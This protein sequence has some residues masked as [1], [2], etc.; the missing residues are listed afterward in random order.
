MVALLAFGFLAMCAQRPALAESELAEFGIRLQQKRRPGWQ[1]LMDAIFRTP[2]QA[3]SCHWYHDDNRGPIESQMMFDR[4]ICLLSMHKPTDLGLSCGVR[5]DNL[6][7]LGKL[8]HLK[9]LRLTVAS[10]ASL[11]GVEP[12][13]KL[14]RLIVLGPAR[15]NLSDLPR[16]APKLRTLMLSGAWISGNQSALAELPDLTD[17]TLL[18]CE[19]FDLFP[20]LPRLPR[21]RSCCLEYCAWLILANSQRLRPSYIP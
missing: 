6:R 20:E 4:I 17:L 9:G 5:V 7:S 3:N 15:L 13:P 14:E 16:V 10:F 8:P 11:D 1:R 18:K 19:T 12:L 21:L 2:L